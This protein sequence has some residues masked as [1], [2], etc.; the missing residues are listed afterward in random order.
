MFA[1]VIVLYVVYLS[2][3]LGRFAA[4]PIHFVRAVSF[5]A[6]MTY[7]IAPYRWL[8]LHAMFR[9]EV[10][11]R[12]A[13]AV[14]WLATIPE[15]VVLLCRGRNVSIASDGGNTIVV[16][17]PRYDGRPVRMEFAM[18]HYGYIRLAA[19]IPASVELELVGDLLGAEL[20]AKSRGTYLAF[21]SMECL[22]PGGCGRC[23]NRRG[24]HYG[25]VR[26]C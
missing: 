7:T 24:L 9:T 4:D 6:R 16:D 14:M 21:P 26:R 1:V 17:S 23:V 3:S 2:L 25:A 15:I 5:N 8:E 22:S 10:Q 20:M 11:S 19:A 13:R 18:T 12:V